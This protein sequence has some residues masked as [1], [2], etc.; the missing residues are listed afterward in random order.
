MALFISLI[1]IACALFISW[2]LIEKWNRHWSL[3]YNLRQRRQL[4]CLGT[5][6]ALIAFMSL[7]FT[8][9]LPVHQTVREFLIFVLA[10]PIGISWIVFGN[11]MIRN[12]FKK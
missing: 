10:V 11:I 1:C 7:S 8:K 12:M 2:A 5:G 6:L 3:R 9:I 4:G